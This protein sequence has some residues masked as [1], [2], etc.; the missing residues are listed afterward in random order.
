M[1]HDGE[2]WQSGLELGEYGSEV[3]YREG[4]T[5]EY[6]RSYIHTKN[7]TDNKASTRHRNSSG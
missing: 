4:G 1:Q 6:E 2:D 7:A 3:E 5:D